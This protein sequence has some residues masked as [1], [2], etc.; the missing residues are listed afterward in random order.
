MKIEFAPMEGLTTYIYRNAHNRY[1]GG[2]DTYF[3]PFISVHKDKKLNFKE[4]N[5]ILPD[6]NKGFKL[7]PQVMA[8]DVDEF[9]FTSS[10]IKDMGYDHINLNFGC[11]SGTVTAKGKGAG[12]LIYPDKL[13][14]FLDGVFSKTDFKFSV[15]TRIGYLDTDEFDG[16]LKI[17]EKFP[18]EELIIHGRV[19]EEFYNGKSRIDFVAKSIKDISK[20]M[21]ISYNGDITNL[22]DYWNMKTLIPDLYGCMIG[23]GILSN[24][25]LGIVIKNADSD[26][27][28]DTNFENNNSEDVINNSSGVNVEDFINFNLEILEGY[29]RIM[30]GDKNCLFRLKELW[31]YMSSI[32]KDQK[33]MLKSVQ[34]LK[35]IKE[36]ELVLKS[37]KAEDIA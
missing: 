8:S 4:K 3:S 25:A 28:K 9:I 35:S 33:K 34:K 36:Y 10:Q 2:I 24:P 11:P 5:D 37:I 1:F 32:F 19:R 21:K 30:S 15:K 13:E 14:S 6:N 17:Y 18:L 22:D 27:I 20:E 12:A 16:L 29:E 26:L 23:R 7:I 31:F